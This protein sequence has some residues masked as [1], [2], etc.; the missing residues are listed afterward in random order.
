MATTTG[1]E[2]LGAAAYLGAPKKP[3]TTTTAKANRASGNV[4][5]YGTGNWAGESG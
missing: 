1:W 5:S 2:K 3:A 4:P